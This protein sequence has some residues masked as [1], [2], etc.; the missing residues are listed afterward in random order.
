MSYKLLYLPTKE[1]I[2]E[3]GCTIMLHDG[4]IFTYDTTK[5]I[6]ELLPMCVV[7]EPKIVH[8]KYNIME[9]IGPPSHFAMDFLVAGEVIPEHSIRSALYDT[10]FNR[11]L[12]RGEE[13]DGIPDK[14]IGV[15]VEVVQ[16]CCSKCNTWH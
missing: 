13:E 6:R 12:P 5:H 9:V 2:W 10:T 16:V 11:I 8:F 7:A 3:D 1:Q 4:S 14:G 15:L